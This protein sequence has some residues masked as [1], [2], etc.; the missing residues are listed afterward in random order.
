[1]ILDVGEDW[2]YLGVGDVSYL[3]ALVF[4]VIVVVG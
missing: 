4:L 2:Q 1:M 3:L